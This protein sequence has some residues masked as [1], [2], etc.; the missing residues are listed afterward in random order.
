[1][2]PHVQS[3]LKTATATIAGKSSLTADATVIRQFIFAL[4]EGGVMIQFPA[5]LSKA[6]VEDLADYLETF[7]MRLRRETKPDEAANW[8]GP[9]RRGLFDAI[10][11]SQRRGVITRNYGKRRGNSTIRKRA[12]GFNPR[13]RSSR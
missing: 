1:M 11:Q 8:G 5:E 2:T 7:M 10:S 9:R 3:S 13:A 12:T 6:S 4:D